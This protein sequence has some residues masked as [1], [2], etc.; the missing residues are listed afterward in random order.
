MD[1]KKYQN[2]D[3]QLDTSGQIVGFY[4]REFYVFSNFSSFEVE[5]KGRT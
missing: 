5:W 4:E 3:F 1:N 2:R